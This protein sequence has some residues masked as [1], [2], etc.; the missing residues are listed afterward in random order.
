MSDFVNTLCCEMLHCG[1]LDL[2]SAEELLNEYSFLDIWEVLDDTK[3]I[4]EKI[5]DI[6]QVIYCI[7]DMV[8]QQFMQHNKLDLEMWR[9]YEIRT[10]Y[11]DNLLYFKSDKL[12]NKFNRWVKWK[13]RV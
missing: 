1:Y 9:D 4:F 13:N 11:M 7:Y 12:Q 6:N 5:D 10:N 2:R 3:W 8:V